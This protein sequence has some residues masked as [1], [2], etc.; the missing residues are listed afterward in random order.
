MRPV[1]FGPKAVGY[2]VGPISWQ[3]WLATFVVVA[4][5]AGL[6]F[7]FHPQSFGLPTWSKPAATAVLVVAY[8]L[9]TFLTYGNEDRG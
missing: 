8:L 5:I 3:G 2:G 4:A 6:R 1:W 7:F 9:L